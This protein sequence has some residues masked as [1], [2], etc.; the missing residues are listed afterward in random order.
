MGKQGKVGGAEEEE[1]AYATSAEMEDVK[2]S[3][4]ALKKIQE[5]NNLQMQSQMDKLM[6]L[7]ANFMNGQTGREL[8]DRQSSYQGNFFENS[9][10]VVVPTQVLTPQVSP[11]ATIAM[12]NSGKR[13]STDPVPVTAGMNPKLAIP[14]GV[15]LN[16]SRPLGSY[17]HVPIIL[18]EQN[19]GPRG[20]DSPHGRA[21]Y[22]NSPEPSYRNDNEVNLS[23]GV[24]PYWPMQW[25]TSVTT[26][27]LNSPSFD[28]YLEPEQHSR[29]QHF[30][31]NNRVQAIL[32]SPKLN[33]P[34]FDGTDPDGWIAKAEKYFEVARMPLEQRS[35]YAV[36]YL[37]GRASYWWRGTGCNATTLPWYQFCRM[38]GDRFA[39]SS[40]YDNVRVFHWLEQTGTI[41][42]YVDQFEEAMSLIRRDNPA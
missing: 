13:E 38:L 34:E 41:K 39:E 9:P 12:L 21:H 37:K 2:K 32:K 25:A 18:G 42:A 1:R 27:P 8:S 5:D 3:I 11:V 19:G 31:E 17:N 40:I 10:S 28:N 6:G 29:H 35:E 30:P 26:Q 20:I 22:T 36:T 33:F 14:P 7:M 23:A 15:S 4:E 24:G 16:Q